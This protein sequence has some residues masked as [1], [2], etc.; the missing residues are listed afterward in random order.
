MRFSQTGK[1]LRW[2]AG[3]RSFL[4]WEAQIEKYFFFKKSLKI[5]RYSKN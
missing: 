2:E 4:K 5:S 3:K 1:S